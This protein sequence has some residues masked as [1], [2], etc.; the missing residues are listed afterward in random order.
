MPKQ[1][2][3][4]ELLRRWSEIAPGECE[5]DG[6]YWRFKPQHVGSHFDRPFVFPALILAALI[7]AIR[8]RGWHFTL[9]TGLES[10]YC[11]DVSLGTGKPGDST[12][13][14]AAEPCDALLQ[15]YCQMLGIVEGAA[16]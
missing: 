14:H 12:F 7:E 8:A 1:V 4:Q 3:R 16:S 2:D 10:E 5:I 15:A 11:A 13:S 6:D 9:E